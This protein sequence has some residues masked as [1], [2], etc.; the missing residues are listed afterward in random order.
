[1]DV[2]LKVPAAHDIQVR[3]VVGV[4][5]ARTK[6]PGE[7]ILTGT[8]A[9]AGLLSLSHVPSPQMVAGLIPPAQYWPATQP[10]HAVALVELPAAVWIVPA[11]QLPWG[12]QLD[13]LSPLEYCPLEHTAHVRSAVADGALLTNVPAVQVD[14]RA[15]T[16]ALEM[17]LNEPLAHAA[18]TRSVIAV[19]SEPTKVPGKHGVFATHGVAGLRSLSQVPAAQAI[20]GAVPP[21]Q[22]CPAVHAVHTAG[23]VEVPEE[24]SSVPAAQVPCD[25]HDV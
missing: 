11:A 18:H 24:I 13:W 5:S 20:G 7:Q 16:P 3:S 25:W 10:S 4:A 1:L 6:V 2:E 21:A 15:Q 22:Y 9:V 12:R 8:Q 14:H 19:P 23:D 17:V